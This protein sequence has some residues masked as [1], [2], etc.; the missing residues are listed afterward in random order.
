MVVAQLTGIQ[1]LA[2]AVMAD[3]RASNYYIGGFQRLSPEVLEFMAMAAL[4]SYPSEAVL[5]DLLED[6]RVPMRVAALEQELLEELAWVTGLPGHVWSL[7]AS[8]FGEHGPVLRSNVVLACQRSVAYLRHKT[9]D[10]AKELLWSLAQ[11]S[12]AGNLDALAAATEPP[13]EPTSKKVWTLLK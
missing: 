3:P 11:G 10:P 9:L 6:D 5:A 2:A 13:A 4:A 7:I 1:S 12:I 8:L